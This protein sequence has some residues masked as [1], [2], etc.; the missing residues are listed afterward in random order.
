MDQKEKL[1]GDGYKRFES[2]EDFAEEEAQFVKDGRAWMHLT[3]AIPKVPYPDGWGI[4]VTW[5]PEDSEGQGE[6]NHILVSVMTTNDS[7]DEPSY[8]G[9]GSTL[10]EACDVARESIPQFPPLEDDPTVAHEPQGDENGPS[11][12]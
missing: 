12:P 4:A 10:E 11:V 9:R 3:E 7:R 6:H 1:M 2:V 5:D 8:W